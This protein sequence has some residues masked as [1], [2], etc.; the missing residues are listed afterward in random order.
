MMTEL[1][2]NLAVLAAT[3]NCGAMLL[4]QQDFP[5]AIECLTRAL[6]SSKAMMIQEISGTASPQSPSADA[7]E[8]TR[9]HLSIDDWM[10]EIPSDSSFGTTSGQFV[11]NQAIII[12]TRGDQ[13]DH[14]MAEDRLNLSCIAIIFN[15][16]LAYQA[17]AVRTSK[18]TFALKALKLFEHAVGLQNNQMNGNPT[19]SRGPLFLLAA[20]N[21]A[22]YL[23]RILGHT[24][25]SD[26]FSH[27]ILSILMYTVVAGGDTSQYKDFFKNV[28]R[29]IHPTCAEG[30][31]AA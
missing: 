31:G 12:P 2:R 28:T 4:D 29:L 9:P 21:N 10:Q 23:H 15:I 25:E 26:A 18:R 17:I 11:Y 5:G 19:S 8:S 7:A 30:A 1:D 20:L 14:I 16:S 6:R 13:E 3:N 22:G 24:K 27:K